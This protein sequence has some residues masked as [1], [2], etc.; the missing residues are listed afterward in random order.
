MGDKFGDEEHKGY[1][2]FKA[3]LQAN[4]LAAKHATGDDDESKQAR[5]SSGIE[6][7]KAAKEFHSG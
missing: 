3:K 6:T 2:R 5:R 1:Q 4:A 7:T